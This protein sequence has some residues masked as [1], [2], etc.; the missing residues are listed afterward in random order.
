MTEEQKAPYAKK[1]A[2]DKE[3]EHKQAAELAKHGYYTLEDGS[4][5]TDPENAKLL[6][7][8]KKRS[9]SKS[10]VSSNEGELDV[11]S[12]PRTKSAKPK[13]GESAKLEVKTGKKKPEAKVTEPAKKQKQKSQA[14]PQDD[15]SGKGK[16]LPK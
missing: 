2:L 15:P 13:V 16:S 7:I 10:S 4:K 6:K 12:A 14:E 11:K 8:K 5:S 9:R 3:R 1:A